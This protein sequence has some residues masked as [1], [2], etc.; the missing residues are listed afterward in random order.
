M[1]VQQFDCNRYTIIII[2]FLTFNVFTKFF[3][4]KNM[5]LKQIKNMPTVY[6]I[7]YSI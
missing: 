2:I 4:K 7:N 5:T 1:L 3:V 6:I